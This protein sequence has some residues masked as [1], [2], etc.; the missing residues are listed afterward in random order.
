[1]RYGVTTHLGVG[2]VSSEPLEDHFTTIQKSRPSFP[3]RD[4]SPV[5]LSLDGGILRRQGHKV[6]KSSPLVETGSDRYDYKVP[7]SLALGR[8]E[9]SDSDFSYGGH[10]DVEFYEV[11]TVDVHVGPTQG[12]LL[13]NLHRRHYPSLSSG[14]DD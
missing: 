3:R 10:P 8:G 7:L 4:D 2:S 5:I 13:R 14:E 11:F 1:M 9:R 12:Q 6:Y